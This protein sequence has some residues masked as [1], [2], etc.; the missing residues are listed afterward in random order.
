MG[1]SLKQI[2]LLIYLLIFNS[3]ASA[4]FQRNI[5]EGQ[6]KCSDHN[7]F[8]ME[9]KISEKGYELFENQ[10]LMN[11]K[12]YKKFQPKV[13]QQSSYSYGIDFAAPQ[14]I[15]GEPHYQILQTGEANKWTG[16]YPSVFREE[17]LSLASNTK[18]LLLNIPL[19]YQATLDPESKKEL[20]CD[21]KLELDQYESL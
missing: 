1:V 17:L 16:F 12:D 14:I 4:S 18:T 8:S 2:A 5:I 10:S 9:L 6:I 15:Y 13:L 7:G 11:K 21:L 3:Y 19:I 20:N